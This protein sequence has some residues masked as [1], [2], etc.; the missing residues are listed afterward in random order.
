[1]IVLSLWAGFSLAVVFST[2]QGGQSGRRELQTTTRECRY[3]IQSRQSLFLTE[4]LCILVS[5]IECPYTDFSIPVMSLIPV[6]M[7][8]KVWCLHAH[9]E[10]WIFIALYT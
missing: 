4:T 9:I 7:A 1:M 6:S 10:T 8:F 5:L 3:G 2:A